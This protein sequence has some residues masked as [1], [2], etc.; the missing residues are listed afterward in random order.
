MTPLS[1]PMNPQYRL[2]K[3]LQTSKGL[4][5]HDL[6]LLSGEKLVREFLAKP[7]LEIISEIV[8]EDG[9]PLSGVKHCVQLKNDLFDKLDEIGTHFNILVLR[10]PA[11]EKHETHSEPTG[12]EV[13]CP[14]GDPGNLGALIRSAEAFSA[15][16]V[17]L[18]QEACHP[19]LPK[20]IKAS[21]GSVLRMPLKR[22]PALKDFSTAVVAL[23]S[24]AKSILQYQFKKDCRLLVGEEGPGIKGFKADMRISIPTQNVE[25]LNAMVAASIALFEYRKQ[26]QI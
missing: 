20:S 24:N 14:L 7:F 6:L 1:S 3:S 22:G 8:P 26:H 5:E 23:D 18:T 21:H 11:I 15:R 2:W 19:F 25:S 17:I 13:I 16:C 4:K 9:K 12:L 10:Q